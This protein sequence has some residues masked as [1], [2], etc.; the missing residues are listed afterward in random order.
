MDWRDIDYNDF[1]KAFRGDDMVKVGATYQTVDKETGKT[2]NRFSADKA[3]KE[4]TARAAALRAA[5][6]AGDTS[7][8][9]TATPYGSVSN[10]NLSFREKARTDNYT[11]MMRNMV[12]PKTNTAETT[13][14]ASTANSAASLANTTSNLASTIKSWSEKPTYVVFN[15]GKEVKDADIPS[16]LDKFVGTG[17]VSVR[18]AGG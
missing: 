2:V 12:V 17:G 8:I 16:Y 15:V 5:L 3:Q 9:P 7:L 18:R 13:A 4:A 11:N 14:L 6:A 1:T 10:T